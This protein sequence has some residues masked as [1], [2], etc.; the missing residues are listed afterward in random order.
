MATKETPHFGSLPEYPSHIHLKSTD[1]LLLHY[2]EEGNGIFAPPQKEKTLY[3]IEKGSIDLFLIKVDTKSSQELSIK[4][5]IEEGN[6][7]L[8]LPAHLIE[9]PLAF[10]ASVPL[11]GFLFPF[12]LIFSSSHYVVAVAAEETTLHS[13]RFNPF[14]ERVPQGIDSIPWVVNLSRCFCSSR[15]DELDVF[16]SSQGETSLAAGQKCMFPLKASAEEREP[17]I[18]LMVKRGT[19][20]L[21]G[22][23]HLLLTPETPPFPMASSVWFLS[24]SKGALIAI[25]KEINRPFT[26]VLLFNY[27]LFQLLIA[28]AD[29]SSI[30]AQVSFAIQVQ[31]ENKLFESSLEAMHL[32]FMKR[33]EVILEDQQTSSS[34]LFQMIGKATYQTIKAPLEPLPEDFQ[35]Q[36]PMIFEASGIKYRK[37][38][39]NPQWWKQDHGPF[40][41][42]LNSDSKEFPVILSP[43]QTTNYNLQLPNG[44]DPIKVEAVIASQLSSFGVMI[45][46]KLPP[47]ENLTTRKLLQFAFMPYLKDFVVILITALFGVLL[48]LLF[49]FANATLFDYVIPYSDFQLLWQLSFILLAFAVSRALILIVENTALVR[50]ESYVYHDLTTSIWERVLQLPLKFFRTLSAG[51]LY[52]RLNGIEIISTVLSGQIIDNF[53]YALFA[54][55][56]LLIMFFY[57]PLLSSIVCLLL[58]LFAA[59]SAL[60]LYMMA[61]S[62]WKSNRIEGNLSGKIMQIISGMTKIRTNQAENRMFADWSDSFLEIQQQTLKMQSWRILSRTLNETFLPVTFLVVFLTLAW[63]EASSNSISLGAYVAFTAAFIAFYICLTNLQEIGWSLVLVLPM[64]QNLKEILNI[65]VEEIPVSEKYSIG[66]L[67]GEVSIE[68][69]YFRY[70]FQGEYIHKDI[71]ISAAPGEFIGI[72]GNSGCGKSSLLKIL[73]GFEKPE[74]GR[75]CYNGRDVNELN[76]QEVRQ[77]IGVVLQNSQILQGTVRENIANGRVVSDTEIFE[78][79]KLSCFD[80]DLASLPMGLKTLL[81]GGGA[82]LSGGQQQRLMMARA[83]VGRPSLLI[84]D[85]AT[86]ALD[87]KTQREISRNLE[88]CYVTRIVI[89]HRLST[90]AHAHRIYVMDK[91]KIV[92]S[93]TYQELVRQQGLFASFVA[94]QKL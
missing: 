45:Y 65:P 88:Q 33:S 34:C 79:I 83:L 20:Y 21:L 38:Y 31:R 40:L 5:W 67:T 71:S 14:Q 9:G 76:M 63:I 17:F 53:F 55:F 6:L 26:G 69:I 59:I 3:F 81:I 29:F 77:Q 84:L 24:G 43:A 93:G 19:I 90:I 39:L 68:H 10:F 7:S 57:S 23:P 18:W 73:L 78:A 49:P 72:V 86:N 2:Q 32:L 80:R 70:D 66:K 36:L 13:I 4:R 56:Y 42:L 94:R 87:N 35:K 82:G 62:F 27:L 30:E 28:K 16:P 64:W 52:Q 41:A 1:R 22:M 50:I 54:G 61:K 89:A 51:S 85:E 11:K 25:E 47:K 58:S 12:P 74:Q 60:C 92:Q 48:A 44:T 15:A 46:R 91:G 8:P 37:V 75:V